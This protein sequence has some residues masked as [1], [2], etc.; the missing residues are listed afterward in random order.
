MTEENVREIRR[1]YAEGEWVKD[2]AEAFSCS[3]GCIKHIVM[4]RHWRHVV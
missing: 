4:R 1:R 3:K 2:L